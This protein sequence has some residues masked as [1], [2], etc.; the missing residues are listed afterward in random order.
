MSK[1]SRPRPPRPG[2]AVPSLFL[3]SK[4]QAMCDG[5]C[6]WRRVCEWAIEVGGAP[7][8]RHTIEAGMLDGERLQLARWWL[9]MCR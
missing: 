2:I 7:G 6:T 8:V 3:D 5:I 1:M 9:A 4:E